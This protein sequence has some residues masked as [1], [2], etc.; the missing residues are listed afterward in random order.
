MLSVAADDKYGMPD[1]DTLRFIDGYNLLRTDRN[2]W[3]EL[4][5]D[6]KQL[7]IEAE[8]SPATPTDP[9]AN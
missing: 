5:T 8:R 6:G 2:G 9:P 7:W 4:T 1:A 3:I